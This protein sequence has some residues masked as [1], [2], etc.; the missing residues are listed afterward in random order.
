[1]VAESSAIESWES[2]QAV[3]FLTAI[4]VV[5][6]IRSQVSFTE[7]RIVG[8][9]VRM[10]VKPQPDKE[11]SENTRNTLDRQRATREPPSDPVQLVLAFLR[12]SIDHRPARPRDEAD[13]DCT[14]EQ[15]QQAT[16]LQCGD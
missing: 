11:M 10:N 3:A 1:M 16:S 13:G 4:S 2:N 7:S 9:T 5:L 8:D 6:P 12:M 14:H 15:Q